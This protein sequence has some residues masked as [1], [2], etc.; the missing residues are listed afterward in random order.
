MEK[1]ASRKMKIAWMPLLLR[2]E[3]KLIK[4]LWMFDIEIETKLRF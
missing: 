4:Y 2:I 3:I 1:Y